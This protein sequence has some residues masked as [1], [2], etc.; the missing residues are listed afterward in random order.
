MRQD[1]YQKLESE[2]L[3]FRKAFESQN[4]ELCYH[5]LGRAHILAQSSVLHHLKIHFMM[6]SFSLQQLN[7]KESLGQLLRILVTLPGHL[8]GRVPRGNI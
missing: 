4:T 2:I 3:L 8:G 5:H 7:L 6:L 1:V